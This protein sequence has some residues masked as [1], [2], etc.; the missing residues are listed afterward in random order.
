MKLKDDGDKK[1]NKLVVV[2]TKSIYREIKENRALFQN[3]SKSVGWEKVSQYYQRLLNSIDCTIQD[4]LKE[5]SVD[6]IT[7]LNARMRQENKESTSANNESARSI[8]DWF[9]KIMDIIKNADKDQ[10]SVLRESLFPLQS[11]TKYYAQT[12]RKEKRSFDIDEKR[13][14]AN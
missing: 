1:I 2:F 10:R 7:T 8:S 11:T 6:S 4:S 5:T 13:K 3:M 14:L 12:Q 9:I